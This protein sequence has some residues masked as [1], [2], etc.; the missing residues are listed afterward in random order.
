[1]RKR[2]LLVLVVMVVTV[3]G[4]T[5]GAFSACEEEPTGPIELTFN[6]I[7][8]PPLVSSVVP[9]EYICSEVEKRT[10]GRVKITLYLAGALAPA[11]E[12]FSAT[13]N[14]VCDIG[15]SVASYTAGA[16]PATEVGELPLGFPSSWVGSHVMNDWYNEFEPEEYDK[17]VVLFLAA[18]PPPSIGTVNKPIRTL[19]DLQGLTIRSS[20][21]QDANTLEALGA[22]PRPMPIGDIYE[23]LSK[24]TIEGVAISVESF[25]AFQFH[26]VIK[27]V[28]DISEIAWIAPTYLVMNKDSWD[29]MKGKDQD[30]VLEVALEAMEMRCTAQDS[31]LVGAQQMFVG[32]E[33]KEYITLSSAEMARWQATVQTVIDGYV[34]GV[35]AEGLPGDDYVDYVL[36]R[37]EYWSAH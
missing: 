32:L 29:R 6:T 1:M 15:D 30:I 21:V 11:P 26:E 33:G 25:P 28:T 13:V 20:G 10:E 16:F 37:I 18:N 8:P 2:N 23:A 19:E 4:L 36:E 22:V 17:V 27:Y 24:G 14:G 5:L 7:S 31:D 3:L 9:F 12:V 34:N 35:E